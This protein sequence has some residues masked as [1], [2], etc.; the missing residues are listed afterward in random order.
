MD[1]NKK[2]N[3]APDADVDALE[4]T[5][6][7]TEQTGASGSDNGVVDATEG[8]GA[9]AGADEGK[10]PKPKGV[11]KLTSRV[12]IYLLLMIGLL[13]IAVLIVIATY[14][15]SKKT[16][17]LAT[18]PSQNLSESTLEQLAGGGVT[19]GN[20]SEILNVQSSAV[21]A[22]KVLLR[23]DLEVAGNLQIG[24]SL[25]L[26]DLN[27]AGN[28]QVGQ[29]QTSKDLAVAGNTA[30]QGTTTIGK[31]LQVSGSGSFSGPVTTPQLTTS[32]LQIS[33]DLTLNHH[34]ATGGATPNRSNGSALGSGGTSSVSGSD[35]SGSITINTGGSPAAG[36]LITVN[37]TA[38]F[39]DTPH[40]LITPVGSAAGGTSY[41]VNRSAT[42]FSVCVAA[43]AP[44]GTS[45]G[46]DYW[47]V[48]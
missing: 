9:A 48:D 14:L 32:S 2:D 43:P 16:Q 29:L 12:S 47:V 15:T 37:F 5:T 6:E 30:I 33:G 35:T 1:S 27:V 10:G 23:Q 8:K 7:T 13:I 40:V 38:R 46:F 28:A 34:L 3:S 21:F 17:P 4:Q 24:K 39:S 11:K 18:V 20:S 19:V 36:C 25:S 22:N 44:A 41:Y 31:S 42:S 26:N 45:F